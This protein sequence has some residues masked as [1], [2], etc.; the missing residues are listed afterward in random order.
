MIVTKKTMPQYEALCMRKSCRVDGKVQKWPI[1]N[2]ALVQTANG[3]AMAKGECPNCAGVISVFVS[4]DPNKPRQP[5]R[6]KSK[7]KRRVAKKKKAAAASGASDTESIHSTGSGGGGSPKK[8]SKKR[9]LFR[10]ADGTASPSPARLD[11]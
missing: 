5:K 10:D 11:E 4:L 3:R 7:K 1:H 6:E 9:R 2:A 8:A